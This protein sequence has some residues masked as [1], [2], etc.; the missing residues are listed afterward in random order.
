MPLYGIYLI[1]AADH[2]LYRLG[3]SFLG[4][5]IWTQARTTPRLADIFG[6]ETIR[7][8]IG[9]AEVFSFHITIADCLSYRVE[10]VV[11]ID[12]RL[13]WIASRMA[14]FT[15]TNGR[16]FTNFHDAPT[17]LTLTFDSPDG[18]LQQLHRLVVTLISVLHERS[19]YFSHLEETLDD[20]LRR[21]LI[22]YGAPW[23]LDHFWPH[24]SLATSVPDQKSWDR[25]RDATLQQTRLFETAETRTLPVEALQL[26][27]L[28]ENGFY[29][30]VGSYAMTGA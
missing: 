25:L 8:W 13:R 20:P 22:R 5:D 16:F 15:L 14:P 23:V 2:P 17:A 6:E 28:Q 21:N 18:A 19:P 24:W 27:E 12:A 10:D 9:K 7:N 1:P 29:R 26:V 4:Y 11:E 30:V 3:S